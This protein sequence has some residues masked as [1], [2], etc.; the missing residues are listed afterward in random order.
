MLARVARLSEVGMNAATLVAATL[1]KE[2][3]DADDAYSC[4]LPL[5]LHF[6]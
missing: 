4:G 3:S 2:E 5:P 6:A 1:I